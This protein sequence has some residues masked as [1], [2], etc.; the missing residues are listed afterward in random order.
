VKRFHLKVF[1]HYVNGSS[2]V[3]PD[4]SRVTFVS[5]YE[6]NE[7]YVPESTVYV[8]ES[9]GE[10][11]FD[12]FGYFTMKLPDVTEMRRPVVVP[13]LEF[14]SSLRLDDL[15]EGSRPHVRPGMVEEQ[16]WIIPVS[17]FEFLNSDY[18]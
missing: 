13:Y 9:W 18:S 12:P 11:S 14:L 15:I 16:M 6:V 17:T 7:V 10:L 1:F 5:A 3:G 2:L 4:D 8:P